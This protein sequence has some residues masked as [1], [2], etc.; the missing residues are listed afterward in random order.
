MV[1]IWY[2]SERPEILEKRTTIRLELEIVESKKRIRA[3]EEMEGIEIRRSRNRRSDC[4]IQANRLRQNGMSTTRRTF[5]IGR[6]A[7]HVSKAGQR[8]GRA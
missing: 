6:G 3:Q 5:R 2:P 1:E 4:A 8:G 7:R